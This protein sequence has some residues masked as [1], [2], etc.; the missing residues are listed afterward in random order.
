[1]LYRLENSECVS[2]GKTESRSKSA[3]EE[4]RARKVHRSGK[5]GCGEAPSVI[6]HCS[7][8]TIGHLKRLWLV[9]AG[10]RRFEGNK[11]RGAEVL[12]ADP[13]LEGRGTAGLEKSF[14]CRARQTEPGRRGRT[15]ARTACA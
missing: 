12:S 11:G 8:S 5:L 1:M 7:A 9:W 14:I 13:L 2:E 6:S 10:Q 15:E 4:Q 3:K